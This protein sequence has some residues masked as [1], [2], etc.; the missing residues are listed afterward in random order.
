M[1]KHHDPFLKLLYRAGARDVVTLFFPDLAAH[2]EWESLRWI[3][4]EVPI[5]GSSPRS[6]VA[7]LVGLTRDREGR[8]L[9]VL[10]HPE[11]QM[12]SDSAMGWRV[13]QYNAGL[14]LQQA[15]PNARVLTFVF[16]HCQGTGGIQK[17]RHRLEF[18][19][20][21]PLAVE[22]WSVGLGDLDAL[23]Y[24]DSE[25]PIA[26]ALASWMRQQQPGRVALRLQ[27]LEK[28]LRFVRDEPYR[29]LLVD[30]VR[31]YFKLSAVEARDERHLLQ[32][33]PYGEV[34]EL[35]QTELGKL[36][37]AAERKALRNAL[38]DVVQS[39]FPS[40]PNSLEAKIRRMR[41]PSRLKELI[42]RAA[43]AA[44]LEEIEP[45]LG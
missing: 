39:R 27:L 26:W 15:N 17:Q 42:R 16:Y 35:L 23:Q 34:N 30:A 1:R 2:I 41:D 11:I 8:S 5:L 28:I 21:S 32:S 43:T 19:G 12:H 44:A 7:D 3:E 18:H 10:I 20:H 45:L 29:R 22:Y 9:E 31:T 4:K 25:N 40:A 6:V 33:G 14:T 38:L 37:Q 13:L 24:A 36:E